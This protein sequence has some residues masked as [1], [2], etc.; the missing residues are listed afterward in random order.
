[1]NVD[2]AM[3]QDSERTAVLAIDARLEALWEEGGFTEGV[4]AGP[5]GLMYF[6][7]FAQPFGARPARIMKFDPETGE[8]QIHVPDSKMANGLMFDSQGR[9]LACAVK[10][11][12]IVA[13]QADGSSVPLVENVT[14]N[15]LVVGRFIRTA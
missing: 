14:S 3:G 15:D 12:Q 9:L 11:K 1:M 10:K 5:D 8:T 7:D 6:S 2:C 4:A 13:Y